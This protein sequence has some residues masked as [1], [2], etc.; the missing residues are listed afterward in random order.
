D[1]GVD[2]REQVGAMLFEEFAECLLTRAESSAQ[3]GCRRRR[4]CGR[5]RGHGSSSAECRFETKAYGLKFS[6]PLPE[7][8]VKGGL[9]SRPRSARPTKLLLKNP[10]P[11]VHAPRKEDSG[12]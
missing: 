6:L 1:L 4:V 3:P 5:G 11:P 8:G 12:Q 10:P 9:Q 7:G 2:D